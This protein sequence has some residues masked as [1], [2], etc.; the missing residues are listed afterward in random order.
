MK[1]TI[2]D[3]NFPF[4]AD[5]RTYH[6]GLRHGE[7]ANRIITVGDH[8]RA[9]RIAK[10][11]DQTPKVFE[12][13]SQR[14][15]TTFTGCYSGVPVSIMAIGMGFPMMDF[16][17]REVR[18]V[19]TGDLIIIRLGSCGTLVPE[20]P[21]GRVVVC[22][23]SLAISTNYDCF[24]PSDE[25]MEKDQSSPGGSMCKPYNTTRPIGCDQKLHDALTE[26]LE[27]TVDKGLLLSGAVNSSADTF[28][29]GQGRLDSNFMD[30]NQDLLDSLS[31]CKPSPVT[32]EMETTHLFHLASINQHKSN[33]PAEKPKSDPSS[34]SQGKGRIRV[35]A[36]HITF[37]GRISGDFIQPKDVEKLEFQAGKGCL[38]TLINEKIDPVNLHPVEDSVWFS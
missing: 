20:I 1:E 6:V 22:T 33:K 9:R 29:A 3:A 24:Q 31:K 17:V 21:V 26:N 23:S 18:A 16:F 34:F 28:Y 36:A 32:L 4:T 15:F 11:L 2:L 19:V 8:E 30:H 27:K 7:V 35:A 13:T 14:G 5:R 37:A 25:K 10:F 12:F 38:E